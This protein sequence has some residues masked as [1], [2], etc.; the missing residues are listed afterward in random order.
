MMRGLRGLLCASLILGIGTR[1]HATVLHVPSEYPTIQSAIDPAVEDDTVLVADGTYTG[2][3]NRDLDFGGKN[4]CV[5]S[6]NGSSRT[7]IDCE[8]DSLDLH[9]GFDFYSGEDSTSV[10]QGF[11]ITSGYV[12][13]NG[14][15]IYCRSNSSPTIRDNVIIGN[16]AGFGGGLYC[17]SSSPSIVGN[18]IAGNVAAEGGGGIRCYG[19]AAPTIEGNAIVGN[20][21]AVGG[22]GV[23]CWDHSSPLM[24]G[25]RIS[26]N[27]T[28][29]GGGIYCYD[30]S[31]PIIVGNTIVGNNAEYGGGIRCRDS[32][33]PVIVGCT[34]ADNWAGGYGGAIHNYSSS[35]IVISTILWGD[36]AGTAGAEIYSV[37]VDT[38]VVSYSDVE[39]GWPGEGNIDADPTFVLASERDYRL[40]WHSPCIDAGHPDSLDPDATRSDMGAFFF[41]QDDYLT[42]Y[43]TPDAMVVSQGEELGVT[44]TVIN[45]WAQPEAFWVL[46]EAALP[47][48]GTLNVFG[49]D[50]YILPADAI[51]QR[52]LSHSVP[53]SA[54]L[55]MYGYRSRIG[56]PPS[57]LYDED[58]FRFVVVEP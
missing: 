15:G 45:R 47:G 25:N 36:S 24:V 30:N 20:T 33:S 7:T 41:D 4:L 52:H 48:G 1:A 51:V 31:S 40:L 32:S 19:D 18:T 43:L 55:G 17:W 34:F 49:P 16:R 44:Y 37:G 12:P 10:V 5:M 29:S 13:G 38:V 11:T 42:L 39:G 8:G 58:S 14:G 28:G 56:V 26:G 35:P 27:T 9:R 6:E 21:A 50:Q 46:A 57:S 2:D 53:G 22:G 3:G 54:P 23:C